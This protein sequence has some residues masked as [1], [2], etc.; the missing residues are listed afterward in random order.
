[1]MTEDVRNGGKKSRFGSRSSRPILRWLLR[2]A[3][4]VLV[5]L[6]LVSFAWVTIVIDPFEWGAIRSDRFT[7]EVFNRIRA[8]DQISEVVR[9]LGMPVS[10]PG[11]YRINIPSGVLATCGE[12]SQCEIYRF[13]GTLFVGGR[14]AIVISD[15]KS[16]RVLAKWV[17]VEP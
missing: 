12:L 13:T 4:L 5:A 1:M 10:P 15:K 8:G 17:N 9:Q 7:W 16:G 3:G 2:V 14:E 11:L 6:V